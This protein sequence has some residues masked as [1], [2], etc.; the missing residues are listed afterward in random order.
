MRFAQKSDVPKH[1]RAHTGEKYITHQDIATLGEAGVTLPVIMSIIGPRETH[2]YRNYNLLGPGT[3][4]SP[5]K[6]GVFKKGV[7]YMRL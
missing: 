7:L 4:T 6:K 5:P 2:D 1:E 3:N